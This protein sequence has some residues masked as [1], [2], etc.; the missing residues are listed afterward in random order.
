MGARFPRQPASDG[1]RLPV[2]GHP[3]ASRTL[4]TN[5][6][7]SG[8]VSMTAPFDR[9]YPTSTM[10]FRHHGHRHLQ[11]NQRHNRSSQSTGSR[12]WMSHQPRNNP[13][14]GSRGCAHRQRQRRQLR[15]HR[16][17]R[18][19]R[20][21]HHHSYR[22]HS[23]RHHRHRRQHHRRRRLATR[24][25]QT[26]RPMVTAALMIFMTT[27]RKKKKNQKKKRKKKNQ[28]KKKTTSTACAS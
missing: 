17:H 4:V 7:R 11:R 8:V 26:S 13:L 10:L 19:R 15:R 18:R 9:T 22:H 2:T 24:Q 12:V 27:T 28:K 20:R 3:Q 5:H 6:S 16:R 21:R 23:R 1:G 25:P 14:I